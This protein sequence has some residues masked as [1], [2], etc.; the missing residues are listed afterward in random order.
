MKRAPL[1]TMTMANKRYVAAKTAVP[2]ET[3]PAGAVRSMIEIAATSEA[4]LSCTPPS[5]PKPPIRSGLPGIKHSSRRER[6]QRNQLHSAS[7]QPGVET[8]RQVAF[9]VLVKLKLAGASAT[10]EVL[11]ACG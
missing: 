7:F 8:W 3:D 2:A 9:Q 11:A 6:R 10:S 5:E 4:N 1:A